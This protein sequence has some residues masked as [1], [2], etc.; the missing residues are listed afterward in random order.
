M[1]SN[2]PNNVGGKETF[3][4]PNKT[5]GFTCSDVHSNTVTN[6]VLNRMIETNVTG[7]D[8]ASN[9]IATSVS[10]SKDSTCE[11]Q[12]CHA[13]VANLVESIKV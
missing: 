13:V 7:C 10:N 4:Q 11:K 9:I 6:L 8:M 5:S 2:S 12:S 1:F 3:T